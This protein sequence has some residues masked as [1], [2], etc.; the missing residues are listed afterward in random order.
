[1]NLDKFIN[2]LKR[3][4]FDE[5]LMLTAYIKGQNSYDLVNHHKI[6]I[7][8]LMNK[9]IYTYQFTKLLLIINYSSQMHTFIFA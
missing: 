4:I 2:I 1:M 3:H 8:F 9:K 6:I 5:S 7:I